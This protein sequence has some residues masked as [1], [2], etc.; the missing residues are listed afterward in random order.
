VNAPE[1]IAELERQALGA[2]GNPSTPGRVGSGRYL[3]WLG[4]GR[5]QFQAFSRWL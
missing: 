1:H 4:Y 2:F 5:F 3:R